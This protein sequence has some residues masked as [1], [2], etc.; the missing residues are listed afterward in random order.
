MLGPED[1]RAFYLGDRQF[2]GS[3]K[4][5]V[6]HLPEGP[7]KEAF[8]LGAVGKTPKDYKL[9]WVQRVFQEGIGF[10]RVLPDPSAVIAEVESHRATIGYVPARAVEGA[11][12]VVVL[13]RV[14]GP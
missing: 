10:P 11:R 8:L 13:F 14:P 2:A 9:H 4:V 12:G 5:T 7:V 6:L 3:E 1:I